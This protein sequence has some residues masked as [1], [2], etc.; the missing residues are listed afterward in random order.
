[1]SRCERGFAIVVTAAKYLVRT[2]HPTEHAEQT[3]RVRRAHR[4]YR[5]YRRYYD[6]PNSASAKAISCG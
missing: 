1:M 4:R 5:R 3:R 6:A 2:A